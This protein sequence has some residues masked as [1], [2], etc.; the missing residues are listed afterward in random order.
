MVPL[1]E[2]AERGGVAL[3]DAAKKIGVGRGCVQGRSPLARSE[4]SDGRQFEVATPDGQSQIVGKPIRCV[5][6]F[7][8]IA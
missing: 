3:Q 4:C 5:H 2:E 7:A 6:A 8:S 1:D